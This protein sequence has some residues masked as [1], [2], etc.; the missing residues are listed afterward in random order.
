MTSY[1][2]LTSKRL[3]MIF[4]LSNTKARIHLD[5]SFSVNNHVT[6]QKP[7]DFTILLC[8]VYV[9]AI[10]YYQTNKEGLNVVLPC[11]ILLT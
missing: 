9:S 11:L 7:F 3:K 5:L 8:H 2:A 1:C 6:I 10:K 4:C